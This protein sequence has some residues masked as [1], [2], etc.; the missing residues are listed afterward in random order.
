WAKCEP[1]CDRKGARLSR[2]DRRLDVPRSIRHGILAV[3]SAL[4]MGEVVQRAGR[5]FFIL[6]LLV[7][8]SGHPPPPHATDSLPYLDFT[9]FPFDPAL[10][11]GRLGRVGLLV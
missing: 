11:Y 7:F 8:R 2:L 6:A 4:A 9:L 5:L 1:S 10:K 3:Q